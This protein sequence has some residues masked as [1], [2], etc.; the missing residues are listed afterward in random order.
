MLINNNVRDSD[1]SD[2]NSVVSDTLTP[3]RSAGNKKQR[4]RIIRKKFPKVY[5][6]EKNGMEYFMVDGRSKQ[7][8]LDLRKNFNSEDAAIKYAQEIW[9]N[10]EDN[11]KA[12]SNNLIYQDKDIERFTTMLKPFG[13]SLEDAVVCLIKF[14]QDEL[15]NS[16]IPPIKDL[17]S[18]WH[19]EKTQSVLQPVRNRTKNEYDSFKKFIARVFGTAKPHEVTKRQINQAVTDVKGGQHT[20][21]KHLQ[22]IKNFFNWCIAEE[23]LSVSPCNAIKIKIPD[24]EISVFSPEA[25]ER[26][27]RLCEKEYPSLL[28]FYALC[29]FGG[30]RPSEAE[31]VTYDH[32]QFEGR[33]VWVIKK[34]KTGSRRFVLKQTDTLWAWLRHIKATRPSEPL[35]PT[36]NHQGLQKK[37]RKALGIT[38][39]QDVLRHT[40][41][42]N[43]YSLTKDLNQVAHDMGNSADVCKNHYVREIGQADR[44]KFWAIKPSA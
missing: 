23:Y 17:C 35:N 21:K 7:W 36:A 13:K 18:K 37:V 6:Y 32:L 15:K 24:T 29:V 40:F 25:V 19:K 12:V 1:G 11:G 26:L 8:G 31:R 41:G 34:S 42:T 3:P 39:P 9:G 43:Y 16:V 27:M 30:L 33:E 4:Y 22:Y 14:Q 38:W 5:G 10:I 44:E 28:G 20:R 2:E